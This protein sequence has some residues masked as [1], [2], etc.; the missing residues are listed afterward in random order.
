[1]MKTL[2]P[3]LAGA[4]LAALASPAL[5]QS[6]P[7]SGASGAC[8][9]NDTLTLEVMVESYI[10]V[11]VPSS[12]IY[13]VTTND[14]SSPNG[15]NGRTDEAGRLASMF[16]VR[17]NEDYDLLIQSS[18]GT[19]QASNLLTGGGATYEQIRFQRDGNPNQYIGGTIYLD[20]TPG[21]TSSNSSEVIH[22]GSD[23]EIREVTG[24][25]AGYNDYALG[26]SFV[27]ALFGDDSSTATEGGVVG[28]VAPIGRYWTNAIITAT[29]N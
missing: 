21:T 16:Y 24:E 7:C 19:W 28:G 13:S 22:S 27:P 12:S 29:V 3:V 20:P 25:P 6:T 8:D 5:A 23:G 10:E 18:N 15:T 9:Y 17:A 11:I 2:K 26:A 1:M 14:L 4:A